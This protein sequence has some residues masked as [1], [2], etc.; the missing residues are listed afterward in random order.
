MTI[1]LK[2]FTKYPNAGDVASQAVVAHVTKQA[3]HVVGEG[4]AGGPNLI[5]IGSILHWADEL[6]IIWGTGLVAEN[7]RLSRRPMSALA[8][9]GHL[10]RQRLADMGIE[11]P[12]LVG[13]PGMLI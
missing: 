5:A 13:D 7:L 2:Q 6:S 8:T 9:R 11:S 1:E 3:I 4:E 10:T 12:A